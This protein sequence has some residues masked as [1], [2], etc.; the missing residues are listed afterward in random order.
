MNISLSSLKS[1]RPK[2]SVVRDEF[3]IMPEGAQCK[4][5][6]RFVRCV[7]S[8]NMKKH[9]RYCQPEIFK[10]VQEAD[11]SFNTYSYHVKPD[12]EKKTI[13]EFP[14]NS[15]QDFISSQLAEHHG[16]AKSYFDA[17]S[18]YSVSHFF[19][20]V[21]ASVFQRGQ[22]FFPYLTFEFVDFKFALEH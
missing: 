7:Q 16:S 15:I 21:F 8:S 6:D 18:N 10:T 9:L 3:I 19:S 1:M 12:K 14:K 17:E 22:S 13:L 5:C 4:H 20:F 11:G 2:R